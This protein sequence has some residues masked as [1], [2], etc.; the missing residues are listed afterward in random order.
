LC[1]LALIVY[2]L[3]QRWR[4]RKGE[5]EREREREREIDANDMFKEILLTDT[6]D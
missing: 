1:R 3:L 4:E 5:R 2:I 6:H